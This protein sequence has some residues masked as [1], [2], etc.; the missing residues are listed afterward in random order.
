MAHDAKYKI[1]LVL[2]DRGSDYT[3]IK[4]YAAQKGFE[5]VWRPLENHKDRQATISAL[6]DCEAVIAGGQEFDSEVLHALPN[7]KIIARFGIGYEKIDITLATKL[8]IAVTNTPGCMSAGVAD[9]AI[10]LML[11]I[12]RNL[13]GLDHKIKAGGWDAKFIG[14]ELEGKTVGMVGFGNIAQRLAKYLIGFDCP[15]LAYDICFAHDH[16]LPHVKQADL[17]TIARESDYVSLHLPLNKDT[18]GLIGKDFFAKMKPTAFLINTARGGVVDENEMIAALKEKRIAGVATDV[19]EQE[20]LPEGSEML[21]L[22]NC[23]FTPHIASYTI[24]TAS[25]SAFA[26]I[27]NISDLFGGKTPRNILNPG[28]NHPSQPTASHW[29]R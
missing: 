11:G 25:K 3:F 17:E 22:P 20:P 21:S 14:N 6:S 28:Y 27:D 29:N 12:G 4:D 10:A 18:T 19:F 26:A 15:V 7:L 5:C 9:L 2:E 23:L 8:G 13:T 24:E 16:G 1:A